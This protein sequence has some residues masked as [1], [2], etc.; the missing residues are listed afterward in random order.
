[1]QDQQQVHVPREG[2][3]NPPP[4]VSGGDAGSAESSGGLI[5][6]NTA[7]ARGLEALPGVGEVTAQRIIEHREANGPFE[8]VEDIQDVSG[9][10]E[11]TFEWMEGMI[12]VGW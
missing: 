1:L 3:T 11:K 4:A 12:T 6:I 8:S 2:E 10:G 9:I 7:T 5:N